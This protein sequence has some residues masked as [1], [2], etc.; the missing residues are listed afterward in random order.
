MK[1]RSNERNSGCVALLD[2]LFIYIYVRFD[3]R[4]RAKRAFLAPG[5]PSPRLCISLA[6]E[7]A[8]CVC[9][10]V[11][12]CRYV[13]KGLSASSYSDDYDYD[14]TVFFV[15]LLLPPRGNFVIVIFGVVVKTCYYCFP[16]C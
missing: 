8:R 2:R 6:V 3:T 16:R 5:F 15:V 7:M 12:Y 13:W 9:R 4:E 11:R 14:L 10:I 1:F